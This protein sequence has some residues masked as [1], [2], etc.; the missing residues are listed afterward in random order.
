[1]NWKTDLNPLMGSLFSEEAN[2][3]W[4]D[5]H[6]VTS[7]TFGELIQDY[8][9]WK[10]DYYPEFPI[11]NRTRLNQKIE[12]RYFYREI[13]DEIPGKFFHFFKRKLN[14]ILP[15]YMYRYE[16]EEAGQVD[17]LRT[18]TTKGKSRNVFSEYP[19][20][21]LQGTADYAS[22]ANDNASAGEVNGPNIELINKFAEEYTD[23]D[24]L[25]LNELDVCFLSMFNK[26]L[27]EI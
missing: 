8:T 2:P 23:T 13:C 25:V 27:N 12:D 16:L 20:S 17:V 5:Q 4:H 1:M 6:A 11:A 19:Q 15:K 9:K 24:V 3:S 7:I 26:P 22:N 18:E 21:Q 14:E 10:T